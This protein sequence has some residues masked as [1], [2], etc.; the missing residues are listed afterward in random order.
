MHPELA[1]LFEFLDNKDIRGAC[2]FLSVSANPEHLS[3]RF[4]SEVSFIAGWGFIRSSQKLV[5]EHILSNNFVTDWYYVSKGQC[6]ILDYKQK[7]DRQRK[8][9]EE[10]LAYRQVSAEQTC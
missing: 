7:V 4:I 10:V 9:H 8:F 3:I 1:T 5:L 6:M 2:E